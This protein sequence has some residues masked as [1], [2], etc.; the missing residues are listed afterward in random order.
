MLLSRIITLGSQQKVYENVF[1]MADKLA[2]YLGLS[3]PYW[4]LPS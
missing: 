4:R 2:T 3:T 1:T